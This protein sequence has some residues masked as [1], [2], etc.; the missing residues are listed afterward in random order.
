[1]P[2]AV[3]VVS[4]AAAVTATSASLCLAFD[5]GLRRIGVAHGSRLLQQGTPLCVIDAP[6]NAARFAAIDKLLR[7]W[8]PDACV[9]GLP[10]HPDGTEHDMTRR[11]RRFANQLHGRFGRPVWLVDER[12]SS[13]VLNGKRGQVLDAASAA[14]ILQQ[15]WLDPLHAEAVGPTARPAPATS[16]L[17]ITT[18]PVL[19]TELTPESTPEPTPESA[20]CTIHN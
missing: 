14:L 1:M 9:V 18:S 15:F 10:R 12:Y 19:Q 3:R 4:T 8:Q 7:E 13:A 11:A 17:S 16:D 2:E 20:L 6:D 5:F